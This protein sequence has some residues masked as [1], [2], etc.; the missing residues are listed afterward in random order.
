MQIVCFPRM[1]SSCFR[2]V[3]YITW[4]NWFHVG[5][6]FV[7]RDVLSW[8]FQTQYCQKVWPQLSYWEKLVSTST[9]HKKLFTTDANYFEISRNP[10]SFKYPWNVMRIPLWRVIA[11]LR[12]TFVKVLWALKLAFDETDVK[13]TL[14]R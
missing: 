6:D 5:K 9:Q 4:C 8:H 7:S 3:S 1:K 13:P 12:F 14:K 2:W 11:M 10:S